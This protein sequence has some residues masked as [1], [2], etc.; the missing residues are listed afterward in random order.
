M[1]TRGPR[2]TGEILDYVPSY[3]PCDTPQDRQAMLIANAAVQSLRHQAKRASELGHGWLAGIL[4]GQCDLL[5]GRIVVGL[6]RLSIKKDP[7][8]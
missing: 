4:I 1:P 2:A 5:Q 8:G 3:M 7:P 6:A